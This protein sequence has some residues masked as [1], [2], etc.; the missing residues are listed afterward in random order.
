M[1]YDS[2]AHPEFEQRRGGKIYVSCSL[3][4]GYFESE[5]RLVELKLE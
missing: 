1:A 3:G 4:T 5:V 2:L